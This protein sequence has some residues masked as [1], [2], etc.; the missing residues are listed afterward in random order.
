MD[1]LL[2]D[3]RYT[4]RAIR[5]G[6][7][8]IAVAVLSLALGIGAN[9]AIFSAV[10]VFMFR[11]LPYPDAHRL[12]HVYSTVPERGW[13]Y[14]SVSIPDYLDL[15]EQSRTV[16]LAT[17][18]GRDYNVSG[19]GERPERIDGERVSWNYFQVLMLQPVMGRTFTR[20]EE[21]DGQ[22]HVAIISDGLWQRRFGGDPGILG[23]TLELDGEPYTVV[24]VLPPKF[25]F[26]E[27]RTDIWT[28]IPITGEES[29]GS[30]FLAPVGRLR[31][32]ATVEQATAEMAAIAARLAEEYPETNEG[33][34]AGARDLHRRIFSEEF[35]MG[36]LIASVA[37][38]FMLLIACANVA[39]LMLTRVSGRGREIAVRGALGASR[40]RIVRQLL[41]ESMIVS[42]MGGVLG[43]VFSLA[44]IRGL[45]S[46]M[47]PWFPRVDEIGLDG[48]VLLFAL[49]ITALTGILFGMAPALHSSRPNITDSLKEG[50][51]GNVG[52]K[53]DRLRK[54]L[55]VAEVSLS[56]ALLVASALLVQGF[57]RLQTADFGWDEENV[58]T[59][60]IALPASRYADE[61]AVNGFYR[62]MLPRIAALPGVAAAGATTILPLRGH[63]NSFFEIAGR[64]VASLQ[65]RP[66]TEVRRVFPGYF[67][68]MGT[69]QLR[70]RSLGDE[71]RPDTRPVVLV[72]EALVERHFPGEDPIGKQIDLWGVNREIVGVVQN[73]LDVDPNPRPMTFMSAFQYPVSNMS[74]VVR[75][76]GQPTAIT[77]AVRQ[78]VLRLDPD[79]PIYQVRSL[80][81]HINE[82]QGGNTIMA[83][84]MS[85]VAVVALI[86]AVVGVYG[87]MS[88]SVS[89]RTQ[90]VG[91][92]MALGAQRRT[93]LGM[94]LRQG[95]FLALVG[96]AI[97]LFIAALVSRS[98][99]LFLF[100]VN[101]FDPLTF[102]A[103]ALILLLSGIGATYMP[104]LRATKVDPLSALR[105]E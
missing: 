14:N 23:T 57:L 98:L 64:E 87:V 104:A 8:V 36:S 66:L 2:S 76:T 80:E 31:P 69:A 70:G 39:N 88:Y 89:Q 102:G 32:G 10:D 90:E 54:T 24:G 37:V 86:L 81:D 97:G 21:R 6:P 78:E 51:R 59:F 4:L 101:P 34:G 68:A 103:V 92:R 94:I 47:P 77:D 42:L 45:V 62:E 75:T 67:Q 96:V 93:V 5:K 25:R 91:I 84:I 53:G 41:T 52:A 15:R 58:L 61:D 95:T 85:V 73:T 74:F 1:T 17:S 27:S 22:H 60:Q 79:L 20:D 44:G 56:L 65:D 19:T 50:G 28:P 12:V 40:S 71:D 18:Y 3:I 16:D 7:G 43:V 72:N 11:P 49:V 29:R 38:A 63:S 82:Q 46:L 55:V 100:G 83:K 35:R 26:Y 99:S 9:T 33:W 105:V 30:H 13:N 48:R